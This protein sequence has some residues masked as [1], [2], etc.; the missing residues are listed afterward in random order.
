MFG[1]PPALDEQIQSLQSIADR[2]LAELD[3]MC[4]SR[5]FHLMEVHRDLTAVIRQTRLDNRPRRCMDRSRSDE[6]T[7]D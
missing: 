7:F 5:Y 3:G 1:T 2:L 6:P 4:G